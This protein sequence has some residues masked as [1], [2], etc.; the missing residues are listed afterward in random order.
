MQV[1]QA[2]A[3]RLSSPQLSILAFKVKVSEDHFVKVRGLIKDLIAKLKEDAAAEMEQKGTCD[4]G[5]AEATD[6]RDEA[7]MTIEEKTADISKS[8]AEKAQ[9]LEE[10]DELHKGIAENQKALNEATEL[11][12][13]ESEANE[14]LYHTAVDGA[15]AVKFAITTM[16]EFYGEITLVQTAYVPLDAMDRSGKTIDDLAPGM[17]Y[18]GEYHGNNKSSKGIQGL[19][20]VILHDFVATSEA[21]TDADTESKNKYDEFRTQTEND[22]DAKEAE[23]KVKE[24][25]VA[26]VSDTLVTLMSDKSD[27]DENLKYALAELEKLKAMCVDGE[28]TYE[29]RKAKREQEVAAL[30]EAMQILIDWQSL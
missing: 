29:E 17:G 23:V 8:E 6:S 19:L 3:S 13:T 5:L 24:G 11:R 1:L 15:E 30:K 4:K 28:E 16:A 14:K 27:A 7:K 26:K 21:A 22:T 10:I 20:E 9:L 12:D 18:S 2:A 25:T